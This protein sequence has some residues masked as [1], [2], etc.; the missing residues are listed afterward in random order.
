MYIRFRK[1][2]ASVPLTSDATPRDMPEPPTRVAPAEA[3][4]YFESLDGTRHEVF[5]FPSTIGKSATN[6]IVIPGQYISRQHATLIHK[7]GYYYIADNNSA[8]GVKVNGKKINMQ[9]R[10]TN[11][12]K[13]S[14]GPYETVFHAVGAQA[15]PMPDVNDEKTRLNR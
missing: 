11:G 1:R 15:V 13:V 2:A 8:N 5:K 12:E 7:D 10:I 14:F 3:V 6:D 9:E 4:A